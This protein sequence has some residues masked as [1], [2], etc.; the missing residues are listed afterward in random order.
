[1]TALRGAQR[2]QALWAAVLLTVVGAGVA[3]AHW[4]RPEDIIAGL[5]SD[6]QL[7]DRVGVVAVERQPGLP[8][9]LVIK[10]RYDRWQTVPA[11][12]RR[13]L[14]AEWFETWRHNVPEGIV[15][16]LDA[17]TDQS[18]VNFD[19]LGHAQ[20]RHGTDALIP[21]PGPDKQVPDRR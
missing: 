6:P 2:W 8:R 4:M 3:A 19:G 17:S 16:V 20:L 7:R 14:A 9:L 18:V 1:M 21:S 11:A 13:Q 10:V 5:A 15:A 12:E